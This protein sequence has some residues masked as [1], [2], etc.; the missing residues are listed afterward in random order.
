M[1][2]LNMTTQ[3]SRE[4]SVI[5]MVIILTSQAEIQAVILLWGK[6]IISKEQGQGNGNYLIRKVS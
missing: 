6:G 1:L 2:G 4:E 5:A 3:K